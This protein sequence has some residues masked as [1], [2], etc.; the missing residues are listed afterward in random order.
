MPYR[1][2][3]VFLLLIPLK[4]RAGSDSLRQRHVLLRADLSASLVT[5]RNSWEQK[6]TSLLLKS[7]AELRLREDM[8]SG[9]QKDFYLFTHLGYQGIADS[10]WLKNTDQVRLQ[11]RW[12]D[13]VNRKMRHT[14]SILFQTQ[15]CNTWSYSYGERMWRSGILNPALLELNYSF[16]LDFWKQSRLHLAPAALR[17][18]TRPGNVFYRNTKETPAISGRHS[19]LYSRYGFSGQLFI[20]ESFCDNI[21]VWQNQ[22][23]WFVNA[24]NRQE[25]RFDVLNRLCIR[26]LKYMQLRI[27]TG[28]VYQPE[29]SL[30]VQ[31]RQE[32]LL[33]IFYEK[34]K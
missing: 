32:V 10:I 17:I 18:E 24:I 34:R 33:G 27:E 3:A 22:S 26:F 7:S 20:D 11:L 30:R 23:T 29:L 4:G 5:E 12:T 21:L 6:V 16:S 9:W 8:R 13:K 25:I 31:Y 1:Y 19:N 15:W 2:I 14:Y 28:L